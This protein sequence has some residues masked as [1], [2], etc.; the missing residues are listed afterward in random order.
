MD[1]NKIRHLNK[2][3]TKLSRLTS[4]SDI[5]CKKN[6]LKTSY[7]T[8]VLYSRADININEKIVKTSSVGIPSICQC[9]MFTKKEFHWTDSVYT[10]CIIQELENTYWYSDSK[11][12]YI[13]SEWWKM[14]HL[15]IKVGDIVFVQKGHTG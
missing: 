11:Y 14:T 12:I 1:L 10:D 13:W 8:K 6:R 5:L 2:K 7:S 15:K 9:C 3:R 4:I